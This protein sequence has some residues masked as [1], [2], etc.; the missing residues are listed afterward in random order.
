MAARRPATRTMINALLEKR[1][2]A[3]ELVGMDQKTR[4]LS[5]RMSTQQVKRK[6]KP[7]AEVNPIR[8][9][10]VFANPDI[11]VDD[12]AAKLKTQG[13]KISDSTVRTMSFHSRDTVK[14]LA[15]MGLLEKH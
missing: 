6:A 3:V 11:G 8:L 1:T 2:G 7:S 14:V 15:K 10:M 9:A 12:L 4:E 13:H 5:L